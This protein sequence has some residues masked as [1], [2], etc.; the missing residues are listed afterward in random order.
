MITAK[1][2]LFLMLENASEQDCERLIDALHEM[3]GPCCPSCGE[4][5]LDRLAWQE[6]DG[7]YEHVVCATCNFTWTPNKP[8]VYVA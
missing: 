1:T 3:H 5:D 2:E 4:S 8:P 7:D 6:E